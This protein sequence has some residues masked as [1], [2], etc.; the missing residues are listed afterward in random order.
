[1]VESV[2]GAWESV[3]GVVESVD[4]AWESVDGVVVVT[5]LL[6][7]AG[8]SDDA[9]GREGEG[10]LLPPLLQGS[11]GDCFCDEGGTKVD[12][13]WTFCCVGGSASAVVKTVRRKFLLLS[14]LLKVLL[15]W[16]V[17]RWPGR[18]APQQHPDDEDED[19]EEDPSDLQVHRLPRRRLR[20]SLKATKIQGFTTLLSDA[21]SV[22]MVNDAPGEEIGTIKEVN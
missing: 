11:N 14:E 3:E 8:R 5:L 17:R 22:R 18:K 16:L 12:S 9:W 2:D 6:A 19:E 13:H 7:V 10:N 1:M 4:G 20:F 15:W 21:S